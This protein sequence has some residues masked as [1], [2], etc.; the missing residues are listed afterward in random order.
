MRQ[1]I[2][3]NEFM[4]IFH[5]DGWL[6][7][8]KYKDIFVPKVLYKYYP[9]FDNR[10]VNFE[11]ENQVRLDSLRNNEIWVSSYKKF[12]D[13]FE[14]K[15]LTLDR[16]RLESI[17][18][19]IEYLEKVLEEFKKRTL[20]SCFSCEVENNMPLWAHYASNHSGYCVKYTVT[21]P[22]NIFPVFYEPVRTK[23]AVIP[24][25]IVSEMF[26]S[27][28]QNLKEPTYNFYKFF[29][30][31]YMSFCCKH[32][33]W[34]YENEFRLLYPCIDPVDGLSVSLEKVGLKV[35]GIYIGFKSDNNFKQNLISI[36][37]ELDCDVFEMYFDEYS[38]EYKLKWKLVR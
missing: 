24:S 22:R 14:F 2:D 20:I 7:A 4:K 31:Y 23:A 8:M 19:K 26:K 33:F 37:R 15:M 25:T 38:E 18:W 21:N 10:Y 11:K 30:Y 13:P 12:N 17:N 36:G 16:E 3:I 5:K 9:F 35:A 32:L 6:E 29:S 27:F 34:E 1:K 28:N